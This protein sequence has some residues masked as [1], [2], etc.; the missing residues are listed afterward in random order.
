MHTN[1]NADE[2]RTAE[3]LS[4]DHTDA[5]N[6]PRSSKAATACAWIAPFAVLLMSAARAIAG[7]YPFEL[8]CHFQLQYFIASIVILL[9]L[10]TLRRHR[11]AILAGAAL[12]VSGSALVPLWFTPPNAGIGPTNGLAAGRLRILHANVLSRNEQPAL[13]LDLIAREQPDLLVLHEINARWIG[14]LAVLADDYPYRDGAQ[15]ED[16][17]GILVLSRAPLHEAAVRQFGSS[18]V[19][20]VTFQ[21]QVHHVTLQ[22]VATHTMPPMSAAAQSARDEHLTR[23]IAFAK[24]RSEPLII[25]GDLNTTMW[26]PSHRR[27]CDELGLANTRRGFGVLPSWP[28]SLPTV[29]RI[30]IDHCLVGDG[31]TVLDCRLA[32]DIGSDHL[33]LIINLAVGGSSS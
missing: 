23:M 15:R 29:M 4:A 30:P 33:P 2:T 19:P 16:D 5:P 11:A 26:S 20:S 10:V 31:I 32:P 27:L 8:L 28:A 6:R 7:S 9:L 3:P 1:T 13:L 24:T 14:A 12:I 22:F 25:V 18:R 21:L 17:F